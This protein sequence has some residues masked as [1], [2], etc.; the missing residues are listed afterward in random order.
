MCEV[1]DVL[2]RAPPSAGL[3][4]YAGD[5]QRC[6]QEAIRMDCPLTGRT[7]GVQQAQQAAAAAAQGGRAARGGS[8]G[9]AAGRQRHGYDEEE[10][11]EEDGHGDEL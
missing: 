5:L 4:A 2:S 3:R 1:F 10:E 9:A 8:A 6:L 11:E 7:F